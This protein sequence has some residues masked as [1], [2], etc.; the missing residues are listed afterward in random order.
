MHC[1]KISTQIWVC[2]K[3]G[4]LAHFYRAGKISPNAPLRLALAP[5]L[6]HGAAAHFLVDNFSVGCPACPIYAGCTFLLQRVR[7]HTM[8]NKQ[9]I[10]ELPLPVAREL[11][12]I[13]EFEGLTVEDLVRNIVVADLLELPM[14]IPD[15]IHDPSDG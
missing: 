9:F 15:F 8:E 5:V 2:G 14:L 10:I 7:R 12:D 4:V 3:S 1:T 13:A 6:H 11:E